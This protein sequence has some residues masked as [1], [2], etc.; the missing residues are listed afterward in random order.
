MY[1]AGMVR[2]ATS[3]PLKESSKEDGDAPH[4]DAIYNTKGLFVCMYFLFF[5]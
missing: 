2:H 5:F 3:L 4:W 1:V